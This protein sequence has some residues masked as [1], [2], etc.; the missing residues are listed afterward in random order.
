[1]FK[2]TIVQTGPFPAKAGPTNSACAFSG[3]DGAPC[4]T[5]FSREAVA[6]L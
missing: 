3:T 4:G 5:G 6:L 1:M 2:T